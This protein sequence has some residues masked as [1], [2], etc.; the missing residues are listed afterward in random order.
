MSFKEDLPPTFWEVD[1]EV[2]CAYHCGLTRKS[3]EL[4]RMRRG[5]ISATQVM[6]LYE[7][8]RWWPYRSMEECMAVNEA[9][10]PADKKKRDQRRTD[11]AIQN[12]DQFYRNR[13][14]RDLAK[15]GYVEADDEV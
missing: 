11:T 3:P 1:D 7:I 10:Q 5:P 9:L 15:N 4:R 2:D 13:Q 6:Q 12:A 14:F 8:P